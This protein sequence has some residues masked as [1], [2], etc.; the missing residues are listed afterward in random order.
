MGSN[1]PI[2]KAPDSEAK[3]DERLKSV[4][5]DPRLVESISYKGDK[6]IKLVRWDFMSNKLCMDMLHTVLRRPLSRFRREGRE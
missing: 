2:G 6:Q 4:S 1:S 5:R 3:G